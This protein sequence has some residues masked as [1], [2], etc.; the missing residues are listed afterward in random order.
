MDTSFAKIVPD[1]VGKDHILIEGRIIEL[2][3]ASDQVNPMV[4]AIVN[5]LR[6]GGRAYTGIA[7]GV[8]SQIAGSC[9]ATVDQGFAGTIVNI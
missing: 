1:L 3:G 2:V 7:Q 6:S 5:G 4:E 8:G 9:G